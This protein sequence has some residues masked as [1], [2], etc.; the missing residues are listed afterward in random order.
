MRV[1]STPQKEKR[2]RSKPGGELSSPRKTVLGKSS[3]SDLENAPWV[4][5]KEDGSEGA[6]KKNRTAGNFV[7]VSMGIKMASCI[8]ERL[9][10]SV[11]V[12]SQSPVNEFGRMRV[13]RLVETPPWSVVVAEREVSNAGRE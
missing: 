9:Q 8:C 2:T 5:E 11:R 13:V 10:C 12:V 3:T 4:R 1:C 6:K 7:I